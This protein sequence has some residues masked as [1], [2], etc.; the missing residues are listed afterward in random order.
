[1]ETVKTLHGFTKD[2]LYKEFN[3]DP[4]LQKMVEDTIFSMS[5]INEDKTNAQ[6]DIKEIA[7]RIKIDYYKD[8]Q[9]QLR[10]KIAMNEELDNDDVK[11][12]Y[13]NKLQKIT[14]II[15]NMQNE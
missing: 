2:K 3:N 10:T 15:Q 8:K 4:E 6:E 13:L 1:M 5:E 12:E 9:N 7:K 14:K 11:L